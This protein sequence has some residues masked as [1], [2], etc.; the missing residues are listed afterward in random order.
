MAPSIKKSNMLFNNFVNLTATNLKT[1]KESGNNYMANLYHDFKNF[2]PVSKKTFRYSGNT[3]TI[4][5]TQN[6]RNKNSKIIAI[7]EAIRRVR[8]S[9]LKLPNLTVKTTNNKNIACQST[10]TDGSSRRVMVVY[11]ASFF[12]EGT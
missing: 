9:G 1:V 12:L 11:M 3:Y 7:E 5:S 8:D 10:H 2:G 6:D 4:I